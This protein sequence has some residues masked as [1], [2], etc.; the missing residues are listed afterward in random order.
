M[1]ADVLV[2]G[3][4][5][6]QS[7]FTGSMT[8]GV[9]RSSNYFQPTGSVAGT[10]LHID[11]SGGIIKVYGA[12]QS[13]GA[14][15][16][17]T[18]GNY[19]VSIGWYLHPSYLT[20]RYP[21]A[22]TSWFVA[23]GQLH[24]YYWNTAPA[25]DTWVE[26]VALGNV[27]ADT[28]YIYSISADSAHT[29]IYAV[30]T[31]GS[32]AIAIIGQ[33]YGYGA[34]LSGT[35]SPLRLYPSASTSPPNHTALKGSLWV[36]SD[37]RAFINVSGG[38]GYSAWKTMGIVYADLTSYDLAEGSACVTSHGGY[39]YVKQGSGTSEWHPI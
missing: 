32:T 28:A 25:T 30:T 19:M 36:T 4:M 23:D 20:Y 17:S 12:G 3:T 1:D 24:I 16:V 38:S 35:T 6:A 5:L 29:P 10:G 22:T 2:A 11:A 26:I 34:D 27:A 7:V 9:I 15:I 21:D 39:C 31:G 13:L 33:S 14:N 8:A 18:D 37:G